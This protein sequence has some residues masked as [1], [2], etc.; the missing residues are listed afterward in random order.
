M[1]GRFENGDS[2]VVQERIVI[3]RYG[4]AQ[5][6][7]VRC[8]TRRNISGT[9]EGFVVAVDDVTD[10]VS[11]ERKAAWSEVAQRIAHECEESADADFRID[12]PYQGLHR[13]DSRRARSRLPRVRKVGVINSN[14]DR[15][16]RLTDEFRRFASMSEPIFRTEDIIRIDRAG[17]HFRESVLSE[18]EF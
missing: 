5:Q 10:Q 13:P 14:V 12:L 4:S 6:L 16:A 11:A 15:L 8:A 1:I 2:D 18:H 9:V 7:L 17:H 3:E